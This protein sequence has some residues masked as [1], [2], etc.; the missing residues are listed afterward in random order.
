MTSARDVAKAKLNLTLKVIG[1][2]PDGFHEIESLVA[3][4]ALGDEVELDPGREFGLSID[5]PFAP[6]G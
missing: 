4:T 1:R 6:A 5:G 2:R 3:F